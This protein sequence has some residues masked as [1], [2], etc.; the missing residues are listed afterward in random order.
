MTNKKAEKPKI[1]ECKHN[2]EFQSIGYEYPYGFSGTAA[3][4]QFAYLM[5]VKCWKVIKTKVE[6]IL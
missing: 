3:P 1:K 4:E 2:F 5:C 6:V